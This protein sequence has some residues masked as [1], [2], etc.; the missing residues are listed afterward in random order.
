MTPRDF[1]D[2]KPGCGPTCGFLWG[3]IEPVWGSNRPEDRGNFWL[4]VLGKLKPGVS[5]ARPQAEL[6]LLMQR[7]AEQFPVRASRQP[8]QI[9][10]DPLW[11]SPFGVNVYLYKT[12]PM[13]LALAAALLL[14][15]CANVANL[16]LVRSVARRREIAIRLAMGATRGQSGPPAP[17]G[18]PHAGLAG[19]AVAVLI[20][21]WTASS[22]AAFFPPTTLPLTHNG[23]SITAS[24]WPPPL[25]RFSLR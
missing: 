10:L 21:F 16:L 13:L 11:R 9:T 24:C 1:R 12:L 6:N 19:G 18:D 23:I 4:N 25:S 7:I 20:T 15:A 2:A 8:N 17:G 5:I 3:W 14:L 22:F